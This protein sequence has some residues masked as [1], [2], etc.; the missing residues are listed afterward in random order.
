MDSHTHS[1]PVAWSP[2]P[3]KR[4][5]STTPS[6]SSFKSRVFGWRRRGWSYCPWFQVSP[7]LPSDLVWAGPGNIC[8]CVLQDWSGPGGLGGTAE[9]QCLV[10]PRQR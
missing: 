9:L 7:G 10:I 5:K 3:M 6:T 2:A 8:L 4:M 1:S